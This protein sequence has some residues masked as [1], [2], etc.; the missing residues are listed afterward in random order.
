M[1]SPAVFCHSLRVS[2][3][4]LAA[5]PEYADIHKA[6]TKSCSMRSSLTTSEQ[7]VARIA[8]SGDFVNADLGRVTERRGRRLIGEVSSEMVRA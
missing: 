8:G 4:L 7:R 2:K 3:G 1:A 6:S 5:Q